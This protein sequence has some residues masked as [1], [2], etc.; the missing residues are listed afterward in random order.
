MGFGVL[1]LRCDYP[2]G[3]VDHPA[4]RKAIGMKGSKMEDFPGKQK[5]LCEKSKFC[6]A[7][8]QLFMPG[9]DF[10]EKIYVWKHSELAIMKS[11]YG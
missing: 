8:K 2:G 7:A 6:G 1:F 3:I 5:K 4:D 10:W 9:G 11:F